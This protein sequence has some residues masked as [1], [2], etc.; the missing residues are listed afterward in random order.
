MKL[1]IHS[2]SNAL[3][4]D[5]RVNQYDL[6][7]ILGT[8]ST[9]TVYLAKDNL[10]NINV[11]IKH[12]KRKRSS[13]ASFRNEIAIF[14]KL[15]HPNLIKLF[16]VLQTEDKNLNLFMVFELCKG[17]PITSLSLPLDLDYSRDIFIQIVYGV[18]YRLPL[19]I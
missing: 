16:E 4:L 12:F 18:E 17:G 6:L 19:L 9:A 1:K 15:H 8:G 3:Y 14:K 13:L 10:K 5:N 11:A 7:E 2:T